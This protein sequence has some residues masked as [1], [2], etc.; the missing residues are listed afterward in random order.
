[1][2]FRELCFHTRQKNLALHEKVGRKRKGNY[3]PQQVVHTTLHDMSTVAK[4]LW[5]LLLLL[6]CTAGKFDC[7]DQNRY[8]GLYSGTV[9]VDMLRDLD[10]AVNQKKT[11]LPLKLESSYAVLHRHSVKTF[12]IG[13]CWCVSGSMKGLCQTL[14]GTAV[15]Q[16]NK[17]S[18]YK[19]TVLVHNVSI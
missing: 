17:M 7:T 3:I 18:K 1:M 10:K 19:S 16:R 12:G 5:P 13:R 2:N 6:R 14:W 4:E 11:V 15:I 9:P 8:P